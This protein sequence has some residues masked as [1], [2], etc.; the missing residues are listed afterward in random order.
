[1][2]EED[3]RNS[4][5]QSNKHTSTNTLWLNSISNTTLHFHTCKQFK[6]AHRTNTKQT[7]LANISNLMFKEKS[8][9]KTKHT[10]DRFLEMSYGD[11]T[12]FVAQ[13]SSWWHTHVTVPSAPHLHDRV[14]LAT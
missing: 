8:D 1:M 5:A 9:K 13:T 12:E 11:V 6:L 14:K 7:Q 2:S 10:S 4:Y 3:N